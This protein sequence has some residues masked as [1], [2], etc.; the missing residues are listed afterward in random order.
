QHLP[1]VDAF[2]VSSAGIYVDN[3]TRVASLFRRVPR[4]AFQARIRRIYPDVAAALGVPVSV[5]NDGDVAALAGSMALDDQPVLGL[6]LGTSLAAGYID[7][8]GKITGALNELAFAPLDYAPTAPR[9]DDWSGDRG[10]GVDYLSQDAA[11]RLAECAGLTLAGESPARKLSELQRRFAEGSSAAR[12]VFET[13]GVYLG[14]AVLG[15]AA[16]SE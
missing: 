3:E 13:L 4:Q 14:Y 12:A 9:D 6:A 2:G 15:C 1:R 5:A 16:R 7:A 8:A 10:I 11:I